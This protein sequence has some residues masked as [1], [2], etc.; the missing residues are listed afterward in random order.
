MKHFDAAQRIWNEQVPPNSVEKLRWEAR[1]TGRRIG[2]SS[3]RGRG[4]ARCRT[5][6]ILGSGPGRAYATSAAQSP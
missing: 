1:T 4:T 3:T 5:R 6:P 2:S